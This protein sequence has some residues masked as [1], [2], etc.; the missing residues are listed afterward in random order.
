MGKNAAQG[1]T[2][3]SD[4][5]RG[6][7]RSK[8]QINNKLSKSHDSPEAKRQ[9]LSNTPPQQLFGDSSEDSSEDSSDDGYDS[10]SNH[11]DSDSSLGKLKE[12]GKAINESTSTVAGMTMNA[13]NDNA[14]VSQH[15][16]TKGTNNTIG[17]AN[18][19][20]VQKIKSGFGSPQVQTTLFHLGFNKD[21]P[22]V[23]ARP[24]D[25]TDSESQIN[26]NQNNLNSNES[27]SNDAK[28]IIPDSHSN[29]ENGSHIKSGA[30]TSESP[31]ITNTDNKQH[32]A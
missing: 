11:N 19:G 24:K 15:I 28:K 1:A 6:L 16:K 10:S 2:N 26:D 17:S 18:K 13:S 7:R 5:G 25:S 30:S 27:I 8:R 4:G 22:S 23:A 31:N 14:P 3:D 32:R 21:K 29:A 12:L 20:P 9:D